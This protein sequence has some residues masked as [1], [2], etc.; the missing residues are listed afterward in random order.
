MLV[1]LKCWDKRS[2]SYPVQLFLARACRHFIEAGKPSARRSQ[3]FLFHL[4]FCL[5]GH[6]D[7]LVCMLWLCSYL[8][9]Y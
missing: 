3:Q 4:L 9:L 8:I 2:F 1:D 5:L 6:A 7:V